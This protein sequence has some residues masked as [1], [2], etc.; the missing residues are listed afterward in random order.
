MDNNYLKKALIKLGSVKPEL[1]P[2]IRPILAGIDEESI[3]E[4]G[5]KYLF[6]DKQGRG[7]LVKFNYDVESDIGKNP[8]TGQYMMAIYQTNV[9]IIV[10]ANRPTRADYDYMLPSNPYG[11]GKIKGEAYFK[12]GDGKANLRIICKAYGGELQ[13][14]VNY[15]ANEPVTY[16]LIMKLFE[17]CDKKIRSYIV[18]DMTEVVSLDRVLKVIDQYTG[19]TSGKANPAEIQ[20]LDGNRVRVSVP[21]ADRSTWEKFQKAWS[22]IFGET[23]FYFEKPGKLYVGVWSSGTVEWGAQKI[24]EFASPYN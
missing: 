2:S 11:D 18:M 8:Y 9:P 10:Y 12:L 6:R 16:D 24:I 20:V 22:S 3:T 15:N 7:C 1:R 13:A 17:A 19:A 21:D 4:E 23:A 5:I 14:S